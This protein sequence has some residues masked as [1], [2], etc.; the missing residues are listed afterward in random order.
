MRI[1]FSILNHNSW[2]MTKWFLYQYFHLTARQYKFNTLCLQIHV[3]LLHIATFMHYH[4]NI[5]SYWYYFSD[6]YENCFIFITLRNCGSLKLE[7]QNITLKRISFLVFKKTP[8]LVKMHLLT[9]YYIKRV[10]ISPH[11]H[12]VP[13]SNH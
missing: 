13:L 12:S 5:H 9:A 2:L 4:H 1:L 11:D 8:Y 3:H 6:D 10:N 7:R